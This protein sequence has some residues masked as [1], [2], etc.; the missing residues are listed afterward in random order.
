MSPSDPLLQPT[1]GP[2]APARG[3]T[4]RRAQTR[5]RM[6]EAALEV[7]ADVGFGRARIE[8]VAAR[9][10]FTRGAFYSNFSSLD[11]LFLALYA[12]RAAHLVAAAEEGLRVAV[13]DLGEG[14][15]PSPAAVVEHV[16][17][18]L[19]ADRRWFLVH[20]EFTAHALRHPPLAAALAQ[21]RRALREALL[22]V[23]AL[24]TRRRHPD[25]AALERLARA[26]VA[27]HEGM[28]AQELVEPGDGSLPVLH[29]RLVLATLAVLD[30]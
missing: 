12:E 19:P 30:D 14:A 4:R 26:V 2:G 21:Q 29:R 10:G 9:A 16:L 6:L 8:D 25:A 27:V 5:R 23:L 13:R 7:F 20:S 18:A 24:V 22:P 28:L 11:E 15:D 3:T 1:D 17:A